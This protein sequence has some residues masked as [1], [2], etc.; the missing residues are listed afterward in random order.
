MTTA[1]ILILINEVQDGE[2]TKRLAHSKM[3][4]AR[5]N[6]EIARYRIPSGSSSHHR[7]GGGGSGNDKSHG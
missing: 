5:V 2:L 3:L 4:L 1:E 7:S 6:G